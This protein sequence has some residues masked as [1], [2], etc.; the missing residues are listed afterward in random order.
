HG[1]T[2][3]VQRERGKVARNLAL[4]ERA[5]EEMPNEPH[6]LM[7][8]GLELVRSGQMEQG[9]A[10]YREAVC[11]MSTLP[12]DQ[13]VP[14]LRETLLTQLAT[15]LLATKDFSG[16]VKL[17]ELPLARAA[18]L[19]ASMHF[20]AGLARMETGRFRDAVAHFRQTIARRNQPALSP[21]HK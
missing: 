10:Q 3:Q 21:V 4:L 2:A 8:Y 6:L 5:V 12:A 14:E 16:V 18:G 15:H 11:V 13:I 9:L 1:Y 20:L 19:T 7:N 17:L